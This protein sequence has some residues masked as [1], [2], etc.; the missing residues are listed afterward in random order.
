MFKGQITGNYNLKLNT[1]SQC[2]KITQ[3][4]VS[5]KYR[6][7]VSKEKTVKQKKKKVDPLPKFMRKKIRI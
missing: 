2:L 6:V 4:K 1:S 3:S 7:L 5:C